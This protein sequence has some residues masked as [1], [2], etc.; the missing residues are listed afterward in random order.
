MPSPFFVMSRSTPHN[1]QITVLP[2]YQPLHSQGT[3]EP[4]GIDLGGETPSKLSGAVA[5]QGERILCKDEVGGSSPPSSTTLLTGPS[6]LNTK[7]GWISG[8]Y[9]ALFIYYTLGRD[10]YKLIP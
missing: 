6:T 1:T 7:K 5:H 2:Y 9:P 3:I 4:A 8:A 10:R